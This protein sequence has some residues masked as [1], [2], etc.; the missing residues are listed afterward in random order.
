MMNNTVYEN[1]VAF[2]EFKGIPK[3]NINIEIYRVMQRFKMDTFKNTPVFKLN[4]DSRRILSISIAL[5]NN[6]KIIILDE[7]TS[8]K[9]F[10]QIQ[11]FLFRNNKVWIRF[12]EESSGI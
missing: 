1:L 9:T 11:V 7:P 6:P 5:L 8:G 2:A 3:D 12:Q 10:L 4:R